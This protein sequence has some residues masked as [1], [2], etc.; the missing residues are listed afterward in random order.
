MI[1][2]ITKTMKENFKMYGDAICIDGIDKYSEIKNSN[3]FGR[4]W[5]PFTIT[6]LDS[7]NRVVIFAIGLI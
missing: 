6:G 1:T 3:Y 4:F 7:N 5:K 2:F